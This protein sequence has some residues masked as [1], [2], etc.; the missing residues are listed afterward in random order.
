MLWWVAWSACNSPSSA[1]KDAGMLFGAP[2]WPGRLAGLM[3]MLA[4]VAAEALLA[5][6]L[7]CAGRSFVAA[8]FAA[9]CVALAGSA[10][11]GFALAGVLA[12]GIL[13]NLPVLMPL[14][15]AVIWSLN[16]A[17]RWSVRSA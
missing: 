15:M 4:G 2:F 13:A 14:R 1:A 5:A 12:A 7:A 17:A 9:G 3:E 10:G 8:L 11:T 6:L 16:S